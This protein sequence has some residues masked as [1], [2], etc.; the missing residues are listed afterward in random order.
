VR[1]K[2]EYEDYKIVNKKI[3]KAVQLH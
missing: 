1:V 2:N 3:I